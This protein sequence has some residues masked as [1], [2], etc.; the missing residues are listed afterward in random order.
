MAD[1]G[2]CGDAELISRFEGYELLPHAIRL[3]A[4]GSPV[5]VGELAA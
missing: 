2:T 1:S 3:L 5:A 4:R